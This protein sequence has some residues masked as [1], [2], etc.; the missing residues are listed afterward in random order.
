MNFLVTILLRIRL[1]TILLKDE[2]A[3]GAHEM[4]IFISIFI[5]LTLESFSV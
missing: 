2:I 4:L 5:K 3:N 1:F